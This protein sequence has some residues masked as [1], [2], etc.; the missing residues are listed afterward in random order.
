MAPNYPLTSN[1]I[2]CLEST[3]DVVVVQYKSA[4]DEFVRFLKTA[5][6]IKSKNQNKIIFSEKDNVSFDSNFSVIIAD[7]MINSPYAD[8]LYNQLSGCIL[9]SRSIF[10]TCFGCESYQV[11]SRR[12][13]IENAA[14]WQT[15]D[16]RSFDKNYKVIGEIFQEAIQRCKIL[17]NSK[18]CTIFNKRQ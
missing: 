12:N 17:K 2:N 8:T 14:S 13:G 9:S 15:E 1:Y 7:S 3:D 16:L 4:G 18:A 5:I 6:L 10:S 11:F